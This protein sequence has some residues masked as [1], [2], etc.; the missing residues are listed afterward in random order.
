MALVL[1][2]LRQRVVPAPVTSFF[3]RAFGTNSGTVK[4]YLREK[5][6]GFV[7]P[8]GQDRDLFV[9]RKSILTDVPP[10]ILRNPF[11]RAGERV[12]FDIELDIDQDKAV[13]ITWLNGDR[14]PPLRRNFLGE[15]LVRVHQY[16]G[17]HAYDILSNETLTE[18]QRQ[19]KVM[20]LFADAKT[21]IQ[22]A[23]NRIVAYGMKVED[24]P[25]VPVEQNGRIQFKHARKVAGATGGEKGEDA[26]EQTIEEGKEEEKR[27]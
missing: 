11:L 16:M 10:E 17:K 8:D 21:R 6:Y 5:G 12:L 1:A 23:E 7:Q 4:F 3:H 25:T 9:H 18:A 22:T 19:E 24:F 15:W 20:E 13:N 14:I 2:Y 27:D 26:I